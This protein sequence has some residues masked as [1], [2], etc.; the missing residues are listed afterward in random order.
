MSRTSGFVDDVM[1]PVIHCVFASIE[2][3]LSAIRSSHRVRRIRNLIH[4]EAPPDRPG[5]Q[6]DFCYFPVKFVCYFCY[7]Y[8]TIR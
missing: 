4:Q 2:S 1:F 7:R 3:D 8:S 5:L 6:S